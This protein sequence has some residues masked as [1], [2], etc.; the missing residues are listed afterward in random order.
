MKTKKQFFLIFM[1]VAVLLVF[2]VA[3][4][5]VG[6][7]FHR[8]GFLPPGGSREFVQAF[9]TQGLEL[10]IIETH[11]EIRIPVSASEIHACI[12]CFDPLDTRVRFSLPPPDFP[13][14][15]KDTY[16]DRPF[17]PLNPRDLRCEAHDPDW[18]RP[19]EASDLAECT[20]G[21]S[22]ILQ[23]ILVDSTNKK[24][25]VIYVLTLTSRSKRLCNKSIFILY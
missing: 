10:E 3:I 6:A 9:P 21:N 7:I 4:I 13:L 22:Y 2:L 11:A 20:G 15:I 23:Q 5:K 19:G 12:G 18:W 16:C 24:S 25:L 17:S 14:F 8:R 1:A